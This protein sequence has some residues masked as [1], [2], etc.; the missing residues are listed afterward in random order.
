MKSIQFKLPDTLSY[1]IHDKPILTWKP[2]NGFDRDLYK[3]KGYLV[4]SNAIRYFEKNHKKSKKRN[5][6]L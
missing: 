1:N 3:S 5:L 2:Y 6:E 4:K